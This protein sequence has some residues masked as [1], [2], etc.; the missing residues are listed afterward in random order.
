MEKERRSHYAKANQASVPA[1]VLGHDPC[2]I[3]TIPRL[4]SLS[5]TEE[6][7]SAGNRKTHA[8]IRGSRAS[9]RKLKQKKL[10]SGGNNYN[11]SAC[12]AH[13][14]NKRSSPKKRERTMSSQLDAPVPLPYYLSA[15]NEINPTCHLA[16][17]ERLVLKG[18]LL[19][20]SLLRPDT[21]VENLSPHNK[22]GIADENALKG[23]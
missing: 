23:T 2:S 17:L 13:P 22:V 6:H 9:K 20:S 7:L 21:S 4:R 18:E 19:L 5:T 3:T 16:V 1:L 10:R 11:N 8:P 15:Q 12:K 14:G